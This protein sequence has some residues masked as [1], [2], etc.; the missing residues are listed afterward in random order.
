[1]FSTLTTSFIMASLLS[2]SA[3]AAPPALPAGFQRRLAA[4]QLRF[5]TPAGAVPVPVVANAQMSYDYAVRFADKGL[6]VRYAIRP[7]APLLAE[8]RV[9]KN[10]K[11][12]DL[13]DPN[14]LY[15]TLLM[16]VVANISGG[17]V[18]QINDFPA[19]AVRR[20]FRADWGGTTLVPP[21]RQFAPG[22][23]YCMVVALHKRNAADVY[24]FYLFNKREAIND[25]MK[26][27]TPDE[28]A[29]HA[30]RFE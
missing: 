24:C 2:L 8:Y 28:A 3:K 18:P 27:A 11:N 23:K 1:M 15:P 16:T 17:Q 22:Y 13:M 21:G 6:E 5:R 10:K 7:L 25:L 14:E 9:A 26:A 20:E 30:L 29:F 4:S 12:S 19:E